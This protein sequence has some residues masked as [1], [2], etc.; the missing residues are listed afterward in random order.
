MEVLVTK[1][2]KVFI[3]W[4][5][6]KIAILNSEKIMYEKHIEERREELQKVLDKIKEVE[7]DIENLNE[8]RGELYE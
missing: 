8:T 3:K 2:N 1:K 6:Q 7:A 4:V 5:D